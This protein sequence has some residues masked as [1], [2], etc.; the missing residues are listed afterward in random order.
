M[1]RPYLNPLQPPGWTLTRSPPVPGETPS[2]SMNRLTS[3]LA[4]GSRVSD[5]IRL[6][7]RG[8]GLGVAGV[9]RCGHRSS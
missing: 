9:L 1:R 6:G 7:L 8:L 3:V 4:S 2:A 5:H